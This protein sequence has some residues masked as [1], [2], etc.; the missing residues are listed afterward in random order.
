MPSCL[1]RPLLYDTSDSSSE[2]SPALQRFTD[3][4]P[5]LDRGPS[6]DSI[7]SPKSPTSKDRPPP[8]DFGPLLATLVPFTKRGTKMFRN[9]HSVIRGCRTWTGGLSVTQRRA[10][11]V[12]G[13]RS[14]PS[15]PWATGF[16]MV[17]CRGPKCQASGGPLIAERATVPPQPPEGTATNR[18]ALEGKVPQRQPQS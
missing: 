3:S 5:S 2:G 11:V 6:E 14:V 16:L 15:V 8:S 12:H 10:S 1:W 4:R 7:T 9:G 18:D 17:L 13:T